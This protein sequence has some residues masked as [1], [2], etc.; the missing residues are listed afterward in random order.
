[1]PEASETE[2]VELNLHRKSK[3][4]FNNIQLVAKNR[5]IKLMRMAP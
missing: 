2:A 5:A 4:I 3:S 1:M